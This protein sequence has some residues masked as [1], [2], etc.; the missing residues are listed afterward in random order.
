MLEKVDDYALTYSYNFVTFHNKKYIV[1]VQ[2][3]GA[4]ATKGR[5]IIIE[6]TCKQPADFPSVLKAGEN[7]LEFPL[8]DA[9]DFEVAATVPAS[10]SVGD[11]TVHTVNGNTYI[12]TLLN[13]GG[14]SLFQLQ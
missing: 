8:Q 2:L 3:E 4:N 14:L 1:Y 5:L 6:D 10:S 7:L 12:A 13:G 9:A 11:C